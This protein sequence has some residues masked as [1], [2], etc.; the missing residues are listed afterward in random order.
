MSTRYRHIEVS[1]PPRELGRQIG[2]AA[3]DEIRGFAAIALERVNKT[4]PVSR[5]RAMDISRQSMDCA[6]EY[7]PDMLDELRGMS[8]G[9]G[10]SR[11]TR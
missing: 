6:A 4:V 11:S 10:A 3:R 9:G 5:D 8:E 2:E 1:G 7:A